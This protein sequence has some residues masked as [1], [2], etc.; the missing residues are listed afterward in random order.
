[1]VHHSPFEA[2]TP[3]NGRRPITC[4]D[5]YAPPDPEERGREQGKR[6]MSCADFATKLRP[7]S[8]AAHSE[9]Y[10]ICDTVQQ[11]VATGGGSD[12][13]PRDVGELLRRITEHDF[14]ESKDRSSVLATPAMKAFNEE[15]RHKGRP[16]ITHKRGTVLPEGFHILTVRW[17]KADPPLAI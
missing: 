8:D 9:V 3:S 7:R 11:E 12:N 16:T 1:M 4:Y 10:V 6:S 15:A 17:P 5:D 13:G 14:G 2:S